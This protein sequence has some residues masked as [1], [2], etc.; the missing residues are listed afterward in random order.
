MWASLPCIHLSLS[1][2]LVCLQCTELTERHR[3]Y[4]TSLSVSTF[5]TLKCIC[6]IILAYFYFN[7]IL[8]AGLLLVLEDLYTVGSVLS[9]KCRI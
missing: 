7:I 8:N 5:N 3:H 1:C 6:L 2:W 9:L 4:K